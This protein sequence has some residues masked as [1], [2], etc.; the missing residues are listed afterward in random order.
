ME[1]P[2]RIETL[3]R[4]FASLIRKKKFQ[5]G[6]DRVQYETQWET[7]DVNSIKNEDARTVGAEVVGDWA[8][9]KLRITQI[10][11]GVGFNKKEIDRAKVLVIGRLVN[12]GSEK[13]IHEWFHKR[14]GLDEVM[15]IDPKGISLSSLYRISDKLVANKESIEERLVERE[16]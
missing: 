11:E 6:K 14:S 10:L 5:K 13:E 2:E 12:P 1:V 7:I 3:A 9:K 16:R 4:H 8:Y 15:D